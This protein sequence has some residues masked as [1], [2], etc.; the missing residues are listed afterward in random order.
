M[1]YSARVAKSWTRLSDFTFTYTLES[2]KYA[3]IIFISI[4][5]LGFPFTLGCWRE[6]GVGGLSSGLEKEELNWEAD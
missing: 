6:N 1:G 2:R 4:I 3:T 5:S